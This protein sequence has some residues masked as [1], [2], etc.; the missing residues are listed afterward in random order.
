MDI[1]KEISVVVN[2]NGSDGR[3]K[4]LMGIAVIL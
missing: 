2:G 4:L 1:V 3:R